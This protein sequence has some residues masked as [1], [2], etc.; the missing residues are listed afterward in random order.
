[1]AAII[2]G[3]I[4]QIEYECNLF[5]QEDSTLVLANVNSRSQVVVSGH[6]SAVE[7]LSDKLKSYGLKVYRLMLIHHFI[8][9]L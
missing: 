2:G 3:T 4:E 8:V 1:M 5:S 9:I 6:V 7:R